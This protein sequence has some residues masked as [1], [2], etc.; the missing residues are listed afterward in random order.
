L[1]AFCWAVDP[2]A[3]S[4][5]LPHEPEPPDGAEVVPVAAA[6]GVLVAAA[7]GVLAVLPVLPVLLPPLEL[8]AASAIDPTATRAAIEIRRVR[9]TTFTILVLMSAE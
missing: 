9:P 2:S 1:T 4:A 3:E 5:P 7:A 6:A 8:H